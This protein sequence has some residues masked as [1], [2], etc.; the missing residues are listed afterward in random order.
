MRY[1]L[2]LPAS[3]DT[4]SAPPPL[5]VMLHGCNQ[6]AE[7]FAKGTRMNEIAEEKGVIVL[8]PWQS[9]QAHPHRC[10]NWY[11]AD[12]R[13]R[14]AGEPGALASLVCTV[15]DRH[16]ADPA[17]VY[18]AGLSAG[19]STAINLGHLYPDVFAAVG[20]HSGLPRG[21]ARHTASALLSMAQGNPGNR[22]DTA[23]PT[24]ILHGSDDR[25]VNPRNGRF[26]AIRAHETYPTLQRVELRGQ[27]PGGHS[28]LR[29]S[30]RIGRGK[31]Y[32]EH[33]L[34]E[35]SGHAWSGG[36]RAGRFVDPKGP[37]ASREMLRFF[38]Q[39]RLKQA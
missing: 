39:H 34:I 30:Y 12:D 33:W 26:L 24:I 29:A 16:H 8:Y 32:V 18:I 10:W 37:D 21:A 7:D 9:R 5:L 6:T 14:D 23:V 35:G 25:V 20:E 19:A 4:A 22:N 11:R 1:K 15:R 27:V 17:R 2:Y 38:L 31:T 13:K 3:L 36:S 28:Y